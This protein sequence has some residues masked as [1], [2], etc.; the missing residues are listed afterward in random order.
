[1]LNQIYLQI[2]TLARTSTSLREKI[3][4][5][6]MYCAAT[7]QGWET[8]FMLKNKWGLTKE[9][10][11]KLFYDYKNKTASDP[12]NPSSPSEQQPE[13]VDQKIAVIMDYM[14]DT[15][16]KLDRI[17]DDLSQLKQKVEEILKKL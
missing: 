12:N 3:A 10:A 2:D 14:I 13:N 8:A 16:A 6:A 9:E 5:F 11:K 7:V 15:S 1:M 4:G 17:E